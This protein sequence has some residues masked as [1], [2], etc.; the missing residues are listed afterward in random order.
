MDR[1]DDRVLQN[2]VFEDQSWTLRFGCGEGRRPEWSLVED[3]TV[4]RSFGL[5]DMTYEDLMTRISPPA[6]FPVAQRLAHEA[7]STLG[8]A[9]RRR[10][11]RGRDSTTG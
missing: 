6:P 3:G 11:P 8:E 5:P 4:H 2:L 7:V 1:S 9:P 10:F